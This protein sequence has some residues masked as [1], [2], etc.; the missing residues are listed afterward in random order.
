[1]DS[2]YEQYVTQGQFL[3]GVKLVWIKNFGKTKEKY[4]KL[5]VWENLKNKKN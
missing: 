5:D 4:Q 2:G 3:S 1:M